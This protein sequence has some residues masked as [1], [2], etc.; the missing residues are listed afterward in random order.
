MSIDWMLP[1][2]YAFASL[3][4]ASFSDCGSTMIKAAME[5]GAIRSQGSDSEPSQLPGTTQVLR[6]ETSC[7]TEP[8]RSWSQFDDL[9]PQRMDSPIQKSEFLDASS[10]ISIHF[11]PFLQ[12]LYLPWW[13]LGANLAVLPSFADDTVPGILWLC[14]RSRGIHL[15]PGGPRGRDVTDGNVWP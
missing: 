15:V 4:L 12:M 2:H 10:T 3:E 6:N 14:L 13:P 1:S 7:Y 9:I 8:D 5:N 11:S